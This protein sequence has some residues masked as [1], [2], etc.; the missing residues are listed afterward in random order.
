MSR[1]RIFAAAVAVALSMSVSAVAEGYDQ[2]V[3]LWLP[4]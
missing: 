1:A 2:D 3:S 4:V